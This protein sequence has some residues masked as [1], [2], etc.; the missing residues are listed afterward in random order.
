MYAF[1]RTAHFGK[2]FSRVCGLGE[3]SWESLGLQG[4][5]TSQSKGNQ[6]WIFIER[7][8]AEAE[9]SILLPPD[10]KN[11]LIGKDPDAGKNWKQ[12]EKRKTVNAMVGWHH[13]LNGHE[14]EWTLGDGEGQGG[15]VCCSPWG[16]KESDTAK[17]L[18]WNELNAMTQL[19]PA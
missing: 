14:F 10:G 11:W 12:E 7:T 13:Q 1:W 9:T 17:W 3:D 2:G 15:L 6:S 18:N 16:C 8:D 4:D 19:K 5:P